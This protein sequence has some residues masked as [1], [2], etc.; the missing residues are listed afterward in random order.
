MRHKNMFY[1]NIEKLERLKLQ[2]MILETTISSTFTY[3][4][5][6]VEYLLIFIKF[7][8]YYQSL[9][10]LHTLDIF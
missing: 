7:I 4:T 6:Y 2:T 1:K 9:I 3:M 5:I 10:V 8:F